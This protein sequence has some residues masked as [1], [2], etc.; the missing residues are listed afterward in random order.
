MCSENLHEGLRLGPIHYVIAAERARA[1][2]DSVKATN[3]EFIVDES[4]PDAIVSPTM[5]L[6]DYA[7][8]I[9]AHFKGGSGGVHAKHWCEFHEPMRVGQA[10]KT[11]GTITATYRK[12]GKFYFTLEYESRDA[13][14]DQ[15][16][17][18][19][20]ITS[21]LLNHKGEMR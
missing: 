17:M 3:P 5:R 10:I 4:N 1:F 13:V 8:L 6:P 20:A 16:L 9:A 12:R 11:E 18:R 7:L 15:L 2:A 21:V 14:T 19:Q